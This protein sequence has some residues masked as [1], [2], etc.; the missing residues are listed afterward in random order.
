MRRDAA[1]YA[2]RM[3]GILSWVVAIAWLMVACLGG[4]G[5]QQSMMPAP[6]AYRTAGAAACADVPLER[7][8]TSVPIFYA[9]NR[10]PGSGDQ[11]G[12]T[13]QCERCD[14]VRLGMATVRIGPEGWNWDAMVKATAAGEQPHMTL[15]RVE[16]CG[17]IG[18]GEASERF[19]SEINKTLAGGRQ[20]DVFIYVP[21]IN[22][23]FGMMMQRAAEFSHYLGREGVAVVFAWPAHAHPFAYDSD[24]QCAKDSV[25]EF[26][27]FVRFI[28]E[29]TDAERIHVLTS[30]AGAPVV[31][32]ALDALYKEREGW[33]ATTGRPVLGQVI[34][35]ASDQPAEE[36]F[37]MVSSGKADACE[38][39]T[40]Y[41]SSSD[42]GLVLSIFFGSTSRVIGRLPASLTEAQGEMLRKH[43]ERV[44]IVDVT[45][46]V[47]QAGRGD[48]WAHR[49]W[50]ANPWV[51]GDMIAVMR[52][53]RAARERGLVATRDGALWAFPREYAERFSPRGGE[54]VGEGVANSTGGAMSK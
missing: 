34:Y 48:I 41:A 30:S 43:A 12:A 31:T 3:N 18:E 5:P 28:R 54:V 24:R 7:R 6:L 35:A 14:G 4:C 53:G 15:T 19:A 17:A 27:K 46:A 32:G 2:G 16:E 23:A 33:K 42:I 52:Q 50:Y 1:W 29:R 26:L 49:Y 47:D 38:H 39:I 40:A 44:T 13:Y 45:S 51:S 25:P 10:V 22:I 37:E 8:S 36:F 11:C 20:K 9:T 21:G